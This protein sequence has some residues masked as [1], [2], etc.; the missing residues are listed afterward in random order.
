MSIPRQV[1]RPNHSARS[2]ARGLG[3]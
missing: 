2:L 1:T 3:W